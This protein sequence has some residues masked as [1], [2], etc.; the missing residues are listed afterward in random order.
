VALA[1]LA[2]SIVIAPAQPFSPRI[3][4]AY[5]AGGQQGTTFSV[6]VGGQYLDGVTNAYVSGYGVRAAVMAH[7]KPL[8]PRQLTELR[9][10]LKE[11]QDRKAA[12]R[13]RARSEVDPAG[14]TTTTTNRVWSPDDEKAL[15]EVRRQLATAQR[16]P[17]NPAIAETATL[18]VTLAA[19]ANPGARELRLGTPAGLSNPLS[20]C[21]GQLPE[22]REP[23]AS[24]DRTRTPLELD[25]PAVIN[26]QVLPG[27]TDRFRFRARRGQ[28]L[29]VA[30]QARGL[31]PYLADAVP[32]WFQATLALHDPTGEEVAYDD[33]YRFHP[34]PVLHV[35]IPADGEYVLEIKDAIYRGREDFVYRISAGELPFL[36]GVFPL[37]APAGASGVVQL[38]GWNLPADTLTLEGRGPGLYPLCVA[39]GDLRSNPLPFAVDSLPHCLEQEPNNQIAAAQRVA[40]PRIVNGRIESANDW[41]VFRF[42]GRAGDRIVAE[43][44]ARRLESPLDSV[45]KL[46]DITGQQLA[47]SDDLEDKGAGLNTHHS[48]SR[49]TATLPAAGTYYVHLGDIQRRGGAEYAYRLRLGPPQPDFQLRVVPSSVNLRAGASQAL[50]VYALRQ[51]GF[52]GEIALSLKDPPPGFKLSG[53]RVPAGQDR[54]R[55]T[56]SAP[57]ASDAG[58]FTLHLEGRASVNDRPVVR[59]AVPAEDMMQ[60]FA[61]RHLVPAQEL[62]V[63]VVGRSRSNAGIRIASE[64]PVRIPA[65]GTA[66]VRI[67]APR[68]PLRDQVLL[69]PNEPPEGIGIRSL[70]SAGNDLI[71]VVSA[72]AAKAKPGLEGNLIVEAYVSRPAAAGQERPAANRRRNAVATLPAIPFRV[73]AP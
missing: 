58:P 70:K 39:Q 45:L 57:P 9:D 67:W 10:K 12:A 46:T 73:V 69:E 7:T 20:F 23:I 24:P 11:L 25:L 28:N 71:M 66:E 36:T 41:D 14:S 48:D 18:Q 35:N 16:R 38:R 4:Y 53:A 29:V 32:G 52:A 13:G 6:A 37:G 31:I 47:F 72:D 2:A 60:A 65:G 30:A 43:V 50:T 17:A 27:E 1:G 51:D 64:Q 15:A 62:R 44:Q 5:P 8:T 56:L 3:G 55:L 68:G 19:D 61:Y 59:A 22:V 54:V 40:L 42:E 34:D 49:L 21:I 26:G 33:D 63:A